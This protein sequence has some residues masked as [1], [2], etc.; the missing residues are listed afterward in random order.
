MKIRTKRLEIKE[1]TD[2]GTFEGLLSPYGNVDGGDD[3]VEPGAYTKTLKE[4]GV[5]RPL[6]WQH[7][8]DQPIGQIELEDRP[9]GLWA[10]GK[11]LLDIPKGKEAYTLL[12]AGV[13]KALSIGFQSVKDS[14]EGG[15][16]H[17]KEIRLYE[18]SLV[19]FPMNE[20]AL[21]RSVKATKEADGGDGPTDFNEELAEVQMWDLPYQLMSA[22]QC[23]IGEMYWNSGGMAKEDMLRAFDVILSQFH[24]AYMEM[25]P[26]YLDAMNQRY[27][28]M[29]A[30]S[31]HVDE[32]KAKLKID[33]KSGRPRETKAGAR[34]SADTKE[35][36]KSAC[37]MIKGGHDSLMALISDEAG[38]ATSEE[39]K[40]ATFEPEPAEIHSAMALMDEIQGLL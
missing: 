6:L 11:L 32:I 39:G 33:I 1:V 40:A 20:M 29:E 15:V 27:G 3:V 14:V 38:T 34:H 26:E 12:K 17:L 16:R 28:G 19:T 35:S 5:V 24:E 2:Q 4:Q 13:V 9:D 7:K 25:L 36:I 10:K 8:P 22:L 31:K 37:E 21:I 23:A 30:W 18:G